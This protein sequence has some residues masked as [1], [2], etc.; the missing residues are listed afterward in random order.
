MRT[1]PSPT[2]PLAGRFAFTLVEITLALGIAA[3]GL[4]LLLGIIPQGLN[5]LGDAADRT[6]EARIS[7]YLVGEIMINEWDTIEDY[8]EQIRFFD[9]QGIELGTSG[10]KLD[11]PER[12]SYSAKILIEPPEGTVTSAQDPGALGRDVLKRIEI[13]VTDVPLEDFDF[14]DKTRYRTYSTVVARMSK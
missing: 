2:G 14:S 5:A 8:H 6:M 1:L 9:D 12:L 10:G 7:Q 13:L 3:L 4:V 11:T